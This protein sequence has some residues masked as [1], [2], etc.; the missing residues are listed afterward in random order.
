MKAILEFDLNDADDITSHKRCVSALEITLV[1]W[2][3]DQHLRSMTKHAPDSMSQ[4]TYDELVN[5]RERLH[6][7]MNE[8][9][10][11]FDNLLD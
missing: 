8:R 2:D 1:L 4:E 7:L 6:Q 10:I 11:S 5:V 9:D 3:I